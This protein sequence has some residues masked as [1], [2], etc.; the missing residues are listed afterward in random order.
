MMPFAA[1]IAGGVAGSALLAL[2][3]TP[4]VFRIMTMKP[5]RRLVRIV[6]GR[7]SGAP[8]AAE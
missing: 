4:A 3:F 7:P 5:F 2:Y 8:Q 1:A 6:A